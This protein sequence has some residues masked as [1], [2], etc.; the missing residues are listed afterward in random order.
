[1]R[2][3]GWNIRVDLYWCHDINVPVLDFPSSEYHCKKLY[4]PPPGDARFALP[5]EIDR[6]KKAIKE[7]FNHIN[8]NY[9]LHDQRIILLAKEPYI[10][11]RR[12]IIIGGENLGAIYYNPYIG[13][14]L[15]RPSELAAYILIHNNVIDT[16]KLSNIKEGDLHRIN[17][18]AYVLIADIREKN[19]GAI[20][21]RV[22]DNLYRVKKVF[23]LNKNEKKYENFADTV[24]KKTDIN[25]LIKYNDYVLYY[26]LSRSKKFLY[27]MTSKVS[28][29]IIVS[30]S[31]G[32]DSL[33]TLHLTIETGFEPILM[34]NNTGI[35]LPETIKAVQKTVDEYNLRYEVA[36]AGNAFWKAVTSF[37]PPARNYRW[38]CK[39][40]KLVPFARLTRK[41]WPNGAL[42]ILGQRAYESYD[43]SRSPKVWRNQWAPHVLSIAPI[44]EWPQFILWL[45]IYKYKLTRLVNPL[46]Y[47]GFERIGCYLCPASTLAEFHIVSTT[48]PEL[49]NKWVNVLRKFGCDATCIKL[50]LWRWLGPSSVKKQ[51][52]QKKRI[53]YS[54]KTEYLAHLP[55]RP[56]KV[57]INEKAAYIEFEKPLNKGLYDQ[58][59]IIHGIRRNKIIET[60][61]AIIEQTN[62]RINV[63]F[64][65]NIPKDKRIEYII[66]ILKIAYRG[67][68]CA[69]CRS[70]ELW[71]PTN[72]IKVDKRPKVDPNRCVG[73]F[74][75]V[76]ECPLAELTV[77]KVISS[78]ILN[79]PDGW[80]RPGKIKRKETINIIKHLTLKQLGVRTIEDY[81][82]IDYTTDII[83]DFDKY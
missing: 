78:I 31:G 82:H 16:V 61:L 46:Y 29:D 63:T 74:I 17:H 1:M 69:Q 35:E 3:Q 51:L 25:D 80:R 72:A 57:G 44:H 19:H 39:I 49:W 11:E 45:Y 75:C 70:C 13:K 62:K 40:V 54:W 5:T 23:D 27:T 41:I 79:R 68:Y 50:G 43:R 20:L 73:C 71:C 76:K 12:R 10:D 32:K 15:F 38:C 37:G 42:N 22:K 9:L 28:K 52:M 6:L 18:S 48:H 56:V 81:H 4:L 60:P 30:Y 59:P 53:K 24:N 58:I 21:E 55:N 14:Y 33:V 47:R 34:F 66:D 83:S 64:K 36:D 65:K 8:E 67:E 7:S 77:D 2:N 26:Y